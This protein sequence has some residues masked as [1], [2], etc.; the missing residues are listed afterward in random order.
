MSTIKRILPLLL[1]WLTF[2]LYGLAQSTTHIKV[3]KGEVVT[4]VIPTEQQYR[5]PQF[6]PGEVYFRNNTFVRAT[7][8]YNL[9]YGEMLY[10]NHKGDTLSLKGEHRLKLITV[11]KY[12]FFYAHKIGYLEV[13]TSYPQVK[14]VKKQT[15]ELTRSEVDLGSYSVPAGIVTGNNELGIG[16]VLKGKDWSLQELYTRKA[17]G[18]LHF[19]KKATYIIVDKNDRFY[20]ADKQTVS[21]LFP[22]HRKAIDDYIR[23]YKPDFKLR[24]DIQGLL[25]FCSQLDS[26]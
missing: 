6:E 5:F 8:N 13:V 21:K 26:K 10:I 17:P 23:Q 15:L 18:A 24:N 9:L 19:D 4:Q 11:G 14:L 22:R 12:V 2:S 7:L 20:K 16:S 3:N 25:A 1:V